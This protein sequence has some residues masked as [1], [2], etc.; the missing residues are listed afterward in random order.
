MLTHEPTLAFKELAGLGRMEKT[1]KV[2]S[3]MISGCGAMESS[4]STTG[5]KE[6]RASSPQASLGELQKQQGQAGARERP[7][8]DSGSGKT[9]VRSEL[10]GS[11]QPWNWTASTPVEGSPPCIPFIF[12]LHTN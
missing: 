10:G 1:T 6:G 2:G 5:K 4:P 11:W 12:S 8:L 3:G 9:V 7:L